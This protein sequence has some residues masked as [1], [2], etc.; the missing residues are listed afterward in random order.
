MSK[1]I[2]AS[3]SNKER[4]EVFFRDQ[5]IS[6]MSVDYKAKT[7]ELE[8]YSDD[9]MIL[10]FGKN[11]APDWSDYL[12]MLSNRVF[13]K[14]RPSCKLLLKLYNLE[15]YDPDAICRK[16][17]GVMNDDYMWFRYPGE[18]VTFKDVKMRD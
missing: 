14:E 2:N 16:T 15:T 12:Y 1:F 17:H 10:P 9:W 4:I 11:N 6:V 13:P 8:N 5:L 18:K 7:I 3:C